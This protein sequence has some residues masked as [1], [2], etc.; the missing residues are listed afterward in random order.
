MEDGEDLRKGSSTLFAV[1][2]FSILSLFL[3]PYTGYRLC[4]GG[5]DASEDVKPWEGKKKSGRLERPL[6]SL[7]KP[8]N[9]FL[10]LLWVA[11]GALAWFISTYAGENAPFDPYTILEVK[12]GATEKEIKK[13]YRS[14]SLQYHP[15]KNPDPK[16]AKYFAEKITKAHQALT[17]PASRENYEKYGH[18]DGRQGLDIGIA[19]PEWMFS[20][21]SRS[22]PIMLLALVSLGI[23]APLCIAACYIFRSNK[24]LGPNNVMQETL[25]IFYRSKF[26][27]KESQSLVRIPDTL[28]YAMEYINMPTPAIQAEALDDLRKV[29]LRLQPDLKEKPQFWKRKPSLIKVHMLLIAHLSREPI[30]SLLYPDLKFVLEKALPLLEEIVKI[31]ALPRA[32]LGWGWLAP[33]LGAI[34]MMQC[35]TQAVP[36]SLRKT[37]GQG[38]KGGEG[39]PL[40]ALPHVDADVVKRLGRKKV[41]SLLDLS[42]MPPPERKSCLVSCGL[43]EGHAEEVNLALLAIPNVTAT[44]LKCEVDGEE[45]SDIMEL[46]IVTCS[47]RLILSR[48]SHVITGAMAPKGAVLAFAPYYPL[49]KREHWYL[50]VA[51]AATN[52]VLAVNPTTLLDA[53]AEGLR[54]AQKSLER[55]TTQRLTGPTS[56]DAGSEAAASP[57]PEQQQEEEVGQLVS[58]QFRA[59]KM[60]KYDLLLYILSDSWVGC[61]RQYTMRLRV[62]EKARAVR[63]ERQARRRRVVVE[64][65]EAGSDRQRLWREAGRRQRNEEEEEEEEECAVRSNIVSMPLHFAPAHLALCCGTLFDIWRSHYYLAGPHRRLPLEQTEPHAPICM[66]RK[67]L[68]GRSPMEIAIKDEIS[69]LMDD[70]Y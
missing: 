29:V 28:V 39:T 13:A 46:D 2:L 65:E 19:L 53:E 33:T 63:E 21:D 47:C 67:L 34:E 14:L 68:Y 8:G 32:P 27:V 41:R 57:A 30:P 42:I 1:F 59:P 16:A 15:D 56:D 37:I 52:S 66:S 60:G 35:I 11:W 48:A 50:V 58:L 31:A 36:M 17:D 22:A 45:D 51:D 38:T 5:E 69:I 20:R 43:S 64:S 61:D 26:A 12:P 23:L 49:P 24:F 9:I 55:H 70:I 3:I 10:V 54:L 18:P 25:E 44:N 7:L 4:S 6:R 40:Q 62:T